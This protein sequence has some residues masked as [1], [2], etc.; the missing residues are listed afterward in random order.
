M[1]AKATRKA[2]FGDFQTP[3]ALARAVC[4]CVGGFAEPQ[5]AS[6]LEPTC[7]L[8]SFLSAGLDH[9]E[10]VASA[11][12]LDI[13]AD[14]LQQ[15]ENVLQQRKDAHKIKLVHADFFTTDWD[16]VIAELPEP[17]LILGNPPW[18]TNSHLGVLRSGNLPV[19]SNFQKHRGLD[20]VTGKANF[21]ISEWMLIR[22]LEAMNNRRG[23]LAM[24]CKSSTAR[25]TLCYAWKNGI[26]LEAS[27]IYGIDA[28]LHF[29]AAVDA[30]LL[31]AQFA[32]A[33]ASQ[34]AKVYTCLAGADEPRSIGYE[35]GLLV[36]DIAAYQRW[37]HLCG[38]ETLRWRSGIKHDC[39]KVME[40][41]RECDKYRNGLGQ[42]IDI[43]DV[44]VYPMLKSSHLAT[45]GEKKRNRFM[46]VTQKAVGGQ[47]NRIEEDAPKTWAYLMSHVDLFHKR[48]SSIYRDRPAFSVFGVGEYSFAPW[49]VAISG[50]YKRLAFVPVG[51]A[52]GKPVV[53]DDTSYFLPCSTRQQAILLATLLNSPVA[54]SFFSAFIFW[55]AKR[56]ITAE[57][58]RRLDLARLARELGVEKEFAAR[59]ETEKTSG[60][61]LHGRNRK[62]AHTQLDLW[63]N[64]RT[65]DER[66]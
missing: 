18:V 46:L 41:S 32:P 58:L 49:K 4:A 54:R 51:P 29:G 60:R 63:P 66:V 48:A 37:K 13:N 40:L 65:N 6:L 23:T 61:H 10:G 11:L 36:A 57:L 3:L 14:R 20:A 62:R 35:D 22:L 55:D 44:Y 42:I 9:F 28:D 26:A 38:H 2:E 64:Q 45:N 5:P 31:V 7:G 50:F 43:E 56:P 21:D 19:K 17:I 12:G 53:F 34:E 39:A 33:A 27:A 52:E 59:F 1:S 25:K 30:V 47:T 15:A 24:L 16:A 8:G